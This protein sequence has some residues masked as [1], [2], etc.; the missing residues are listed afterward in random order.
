VGLPSVAL[1]FTFLAESHSLSSRP[2]SSVK[3]SLSTV[4]CFTMSE[5]TASDDL[6]NYLAETPAAHNAEFRDSL[7]MADAILGV[8]GTTV[9]FL[10]ATPFIGVNDVVGLLF[11]K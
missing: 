5:A 4:V 6:F 2:I 11:F 9:R 1:N 7:D 10:Q 8:E 3:L